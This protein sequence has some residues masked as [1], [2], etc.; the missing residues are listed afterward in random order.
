[1]TERYENFEAS[2]VAVMALWRQHR[3][4]DG[5]M[6]A[7]NMNRK[8]VKYRLNLSG[9]NLN[10]YRAKPQGDPVYRPIEAPLS[11]IMDAKHVSLLIRHGGY[12]RLSEKPTRTGPVVCLPL[13]P[14]EGIAA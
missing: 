6:R 10:D 8:Q 13:I 7:L 11:A 4:V 1:M 2:R 3:D 12:A 14:F 5:I 9:V